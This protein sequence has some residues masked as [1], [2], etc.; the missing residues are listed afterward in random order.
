MGFAR[1]YLS[2][3]GLIDAVRHVVSEMQLPP[4]KVHTKYNWED[5]IMSGLAVFMLKSPSLLQFDIDSKNH[6]SVIYKNLNNLFGVKE[7]PSDTCLR[8]HLDEIP[9]QGLRIVFKKIFALLQRGGLLEQYR[10]LDN[11]YILSIDGTGQFSSAN[12]HCGNC[13][14]KHHSKGP[15]TYYHHMLGAAIVHP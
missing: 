8:K 3:D 9:A 4:I 12:I 6:A 13:C 15:V 14:Q 10:Y 2:A 11:H 7:V 5:C 1:K